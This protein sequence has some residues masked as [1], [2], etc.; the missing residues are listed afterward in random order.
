[1]VDS[2]DA[3]ILKMRKHPRNVRLL[4]KQEKL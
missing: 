2:V 4:L 1:V 3:T